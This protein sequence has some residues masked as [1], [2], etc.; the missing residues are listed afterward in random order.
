MF[1]GEKKILVKKK[2]KK[3]KKGL[4]LNQYDQRGITSVLTNNFDTLGG[5]ISYM[6]RYLPNL[7]YNPD[8]TQGQ[9][10]KWSLTAF[11]FRVFLLLDWFSFQGQRTHRR[12]IRG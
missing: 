2:R 3:K 10:F 4:L 8:V 11:E 1:G 9:I 7:S 12:S 6:Y 5:E